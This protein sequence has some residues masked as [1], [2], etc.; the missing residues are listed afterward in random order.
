MKNLFLIIFRLRISK[1]SELNEPHFE[2]KICTWEVDFLTR[3]ISKVLQVFRSTCA[4]TYYKYSKSWS[5]LQQ[6]FRSRFLIY[7]FFEILKLFLR[8]SPSGYTVSTVVRLES[9]VWRQLWIQIWILLMS[10]CLKCCI[11]KTDW[12]MVKLWESMSPGLSRPPFINFIV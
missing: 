5:S 7:D 11:F 10:Y 1:N 9:E 6:N 4:P 8:S 2:H 12:W 3:R